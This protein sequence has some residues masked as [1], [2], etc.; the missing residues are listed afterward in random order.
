MQYKKM[1]DLN[2]SD[3]DSVR[4]STAFPDNFHVRLYDTSGTLL[5]SILDYDASDTDS[6]IPDEGD[7]IALEKYVVY[8]DSTGAISNGRIVIYVW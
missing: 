3:Y 7:V 8:Q 4:N 6:L 5:D 1:S 2:Q